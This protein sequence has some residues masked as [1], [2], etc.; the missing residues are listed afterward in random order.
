[1]TIVVQPYEG[2]GSFPKEGVRIPTSASARAG[3]ADPEPENNQA[4]VTTLVLP[5]PNLPPAVWLITP[6]DRALFNGSAQV[7][8]EADAKDTDGT[9]SRV[10]FYDNGKTCG[11]WHN[12]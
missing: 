6:K 5:D 10:V 3:E 7:T 2:R 1:V 11:H 4:S 12:Y 8:F 9:V